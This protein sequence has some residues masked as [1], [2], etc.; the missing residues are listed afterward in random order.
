MH[1]AALVQ[2]NAVAAAQQQ[3]RVHGA[4]PQLGAFQPVHFVG[5][6][7]LGEGGHESFELL[8]PG[9][10]PAELSLDKGGELGGEAFEPRLLP[11]F[12]QREQRGDAP[13]TAFEPRVGRL[14][15]ATHAGGH[16]ALAVVHVVPHPGQMVH[17][18]GCCRRGR[19]D[20]G[21]RN[22]VEDALIALVSNARDDGQGEVGHVLGQDKGVESAHVGRGAATP[23]NHHHVETVGF[24]VDGIEGSDDA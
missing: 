15:A 20:T 2:R 1:G 5:H 16:A 9:G 12:D 22:H 17:K 24:G 8:Q 4:Q 23:N 19:L 13:G 6:A 7:L 3:L 18:Q 10:G 11:H 21:V 14:Q